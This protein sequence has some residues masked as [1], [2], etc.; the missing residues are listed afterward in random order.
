[1]SGDLWAC[2]L[3]NDNGDEFIVPADEIGVELMKAHLLEK[4]GIKESMLP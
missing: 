4:H 1:M 3:C 2:R